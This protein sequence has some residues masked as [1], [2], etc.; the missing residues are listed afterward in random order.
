MGNI[1]RAVHVISW[2]RKKRKNVFIV[3]N[4]TRSFL[5]HRANKR[6]NVSPTIHEQ[7]LKQLHRADACEGE[8]DVT[9]REAKLRASCNN[10]RN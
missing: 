5:S 1:L 10:W 9:R 3:I 7:K 4:G 8:G 6:I 2:R